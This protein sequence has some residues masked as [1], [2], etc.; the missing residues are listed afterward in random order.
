[1]K[2]VEGRLPKT[3]IEFLTARKRKKE[4]RGKWPTPVIFSALQVLTSAL[5]KTQDCEILKPK[6][7]TEMT[8]F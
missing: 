8:L 5:Y 6:N 1:M 7:F 4:P 2:N 3:K